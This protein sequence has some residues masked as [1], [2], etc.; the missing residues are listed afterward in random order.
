MVA[1]PP[2]LQARVRSTVERLTLWDAYRLERPTRTADGKGGQTTTWTAVEAGK[3]RLQRGGVRGETGLI[4]QRLGWTSH[5]EID[6]PTESI[7]EAK[8][9]AIVNGRTFVVGEA[10]RAGGADFTKTLVCSESG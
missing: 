10:V 9:R 1:L 3:C 5:Y 2:T 7:A 8:D 6:V 4:A